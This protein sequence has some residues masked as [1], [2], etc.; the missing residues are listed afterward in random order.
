[1]DNIIAELTAELNWKAPDGLKTGKCE[2]G[3]RIEKKGGYCKLDCANNVMLARALLE[4]K[5]RG[6]DDYVYEYE[7]QME[8]LGIMFD[9]SRNGVLNMPT[10]K[11]LIRMCALMG[12]N[13][14]L[15]YMEDVYTIKD[16]PYFGYLRGRYSTEELKEVEA[17]A[18]KFDIETVPCIQTLAHLE[19]VKKWWALGDKFDLGDI[20]FCDY[21]PTYEL[22]DD[23]FKSM[24]ESFTTDK[25][26]IGMDEAEMV[27]L[28]K[29]LKKYGYHDRFSIILK[30]LN[31]V[32]AIAEK[33]G[34]KPIMWS[35]MFFR[36]VNDGNYYG[37]NPVPQDVIDRVPENVALAYWD[38]RELDSA[39]YDRMLKEHAKFNREIW[40]V[41]TSWKCIGIVPH[42]YYT[43]NTFDALLPSVK[44]YGLKNFYTTCW[45]DN[46]AE[47]SVYGVIPSWLY[48]SLRING[49]DGR[50]AFERL[51]LALT[52]IR[53][54][55]FL[56]IDSPNMLGKS[57]LYCECPSKYF[58]YSDLFSGFLDARCYDEYETSIKEAVKNLEKV[59]GGKFR[60]AFDVDKTLAKVLEIKLLL[61]K[62]TRSAYQNKDI[63]SLKEMAEKI[64]P[65]LIKRI[66]NFHDA[67]YNRWNDENKPQ[68]FEV[69][70]IR[71]GGLLQ[72]VKTCKRRLDEFLKSGKP[73]GE[74][75]EEILPFKHSAADDEHMIYYGW[76]NYVTV[77]T[78]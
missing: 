3:F 40:M 6:E 44:K 29:Y 4:M 35:D 55:D 58:L 65:E 60:M 76:N 45:G 38:Y 57:R 23:M 69:Q 67:M 50:D 19:T 22:I 34:F 61:G 75:D 1:M 74:L 18:K 71:I 32:C 77:N 52:D 27:G 70:D 54:N 17:Y 21:E 73:V 10:I 5:S 56:L 47:C 24:R 33:Y 39:H 16:R 11:R 36:I 66:E 59:D 26:N 68:G 7:P 30:H 9:C 43:F 72:R 15:L 31:R 20:L 41:N 53:L 28:G 62:K 78:L 25:I 51:F 63:A 14:F 48:I 12:Y 8:N 13:M 46:G 64:Y 49:I 2:K 42:N 37:K